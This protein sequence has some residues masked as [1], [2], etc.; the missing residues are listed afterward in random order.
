[1]PKT[2]SQAEMSTAIQASSTRRLKAFSDDEIFDYL[3][4]TVYTERQ[5]LGPL[6]SHETKTSSTDARY[7]ALLRSANRAITKGRSSME[8]AAINLIN[9][10]VSEVH[11]R[12]SARTFKLASKVLP[13]A[14]TRLLTASQPS[15]LLDPSIDA[16][17]RIQV[18]GPM[19]QLR[20]LS[21]Q[22]TLVYTP[23]H[24]SNLDSP[25]IGYALAVAKLAPVIYGAGLNLFDNPIMAFFM[26]RLGAYTVDRRKKNK[27]YKDV[28][29][30]YS[31]VSISKGRHSLFY[32]GGTRSRSGRIETSLKKGLLGTGIQAWQE[33]VRSGDP[34]E[35]FFVPCTLSCSLVLEAETLI[36]DALLEQGKSRYIISDDE[37]SEPRTVAQ[38]VRKVLSLDACV[39]VR[40]GQPL[41]CVGNPLTPEGLSS[42]N[43]KIVDRHSYITLKDGTFCADSQRDQQYTKRLAGSILQSLRENAVALPTH[44]CALAAWNILSCRHSRIDDVQR[45]LLSPDESTCTLTELY[46]E[47]ERILG[48][49]NQLHS[50][51]QISGLPSASPPEVLAE[52][53]RH[54]ASYHANP[55]LQII[56]Q[57]VRIEP[58]LALYYANRLRDHCNSQ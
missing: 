8:A 5:R 55:T 34:R 7:L 21:T 22:H 58:K 6:L 11:T 14:L 49:L 15:S 19:D 51:A 57:D 28:L 45:A 27:L 56:N 17:H 35:V 42:C 24:V 43:G 32:P 3:A 2:L 41:D 12:P 23:T 1:M 54:F 39:T 53:V 38:F 33:N 47:I 50:S 20:E 48:Q 36:T 4:E 13:K 29:K 10:Y 26:G 46:Q 25:L 18:E 16:A 52:A 44:L 9:H 30:D 40:F 37:F 31:A